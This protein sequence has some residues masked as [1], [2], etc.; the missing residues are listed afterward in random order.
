MILRL[1]V[2]LPLS[3]L[4]TLAFYGLRVAIG[5]ENAERHAG[6]ALFLLWYG[7]LYAEFYMWWFTRRTTKESP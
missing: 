7:T 6:I 4:V 2:G 1:A 5:E 3:A